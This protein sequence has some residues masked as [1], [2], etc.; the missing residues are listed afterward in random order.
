MSQHTPSALSLQ[1]LRGAN[2]ARL[3]Q[4]RNKLGELAHSERDGSDW[5]PAMWF[6][7]LVGELGELAELREAYEQGTLTEA[8]YS[9]AVAGELADV[10][11]Y[12]DLFAARCL[13]RTGRQKPNEADFAQTL[14]SLVADLGTWANAA[15]KRVRGDIDSDALN[16]YSEHLAGVVESVMHLDHA[17]SF[18][19][20]H[21]GALQAVLPG[22]AHATGVDLSVATANKFNDVSLRVGA[23]VLFI[24][25]GDQ[26]AWTTKL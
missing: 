20:V 4:F 14:M 19:F 23:N 7:A 8:A 9:A 3:P 17:M 15:K 22:G 18:G 16:R 2:R 12:L 6:L 13:D 5:S 24:Q 10:V 25:D 11:T 26:Y 1:A 21:G